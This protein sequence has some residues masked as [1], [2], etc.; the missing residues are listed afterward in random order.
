MEADAIRALGEVGFWP[1]VLGGSA[2]NL[3]AFGFFLRSVAK[4]WAVYKARTT[5]IEE[6]V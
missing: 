2:L 6:R 5:E 4:V 3:W 1:M